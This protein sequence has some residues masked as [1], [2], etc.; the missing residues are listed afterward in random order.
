[1][2]ANKFLFSGGAEEPVVC[3]ARG[4]PAMGVCVCWPSK[5]AVLERQE[6]PTRSSTSLRDWKTVRSDLY[7]SILLCSSGY[8]QFL[9][10]ENARFDVLIE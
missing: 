10:R 7:I 3:P 6:R 1:M 5:A 8:L 2:D 9:F 4:T